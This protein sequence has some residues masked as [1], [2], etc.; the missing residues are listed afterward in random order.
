M[1]TICA[2][3]KYKKECPGRH[4]SLTKNSSNNKKSIRVELAHDILDE[5]PDILE[6]LEKRDRKILKKYTYENNPN[7]NDKVAKLVQKIRSG[8]TGD[9]KED[10][11]RQRLVDSVGEVVFPYANK[12]RFK[13]NSV[14]LRNG[15]KSFAIKN[16]ASEDITLDEFKNEFCNSEK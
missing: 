4:K 8:M 12:V 5:H 10:S 7:K 2:N 13:K 14:K 9:Q 3:C 11:F 1:T 6:E 15:V 16:G